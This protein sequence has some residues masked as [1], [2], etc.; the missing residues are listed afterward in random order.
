MTPSYRLRH[1]SIALERHRDQGIAGQSVIIVVG[2]GGS[3]GA[4]LALEQ[5]LATS[6]STGR[7]QE[8]LGLA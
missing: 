6:W 4:L 2:D 3:L 5:Q 7:E 8:S 1:H